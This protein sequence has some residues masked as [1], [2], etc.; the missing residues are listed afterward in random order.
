MHCVENRLRSC[1]LQRYLGGNLMFMESLRRATA[2]VAFSLAVFASILAGASPVAAQF[3]EVGFEAGVQFSQQFEPLVPYGGGAAWGDFDRDGVLDLLLTQAVGCN[4]LFLGEG[5]GTFSLV[6]DAQVAACSLTTRGVAVADYDNDGDSDIYLTAFGTNRLLE[7][8][9]VPTGSLAFVDV[10]DTSGISAD[11]GGNSGSAA[12]GDYD[13]DGHLDLFVTNHAPV[14][15]PLFCQPDLLWHNNGDGTFTDVADELGIAV[16]GDQGVPG[17]GLAATWSDYDRDGDVDL[18]VVNDFGQSFTPNRLFRNDGPHPTLP[19]AFTDV[20]RESGFD[21]QMFGMGIAKGDLDHDGDLD[22]Y[23]ADIGPNNLAVNAGDGT[24]VES[25]E[26]AGVLASD[27]ETWLGEGLVSWGVGFFDLDL[28]SWEDLIVTNGGAPDDAFPNMFGFSYVDLNPNYIYRNR[29]DGTFAE[30]HLQIGI[31]SEGF[32]RSFVAAD[33]D[34]DGDIDL[35]F[36]TLSGINRLYR[37]DQQSDRHWLKI[38][39]EGTIGNRD[40]YGARVLIV[41]DG[42]KQQREVDG[43]SSF[44]GRHDPTLHFGLGSSDTVDRIRVR[45]LSGETIEL[46]DVRQIKR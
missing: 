30:R 12:W 13:R 41:A 19:W 23:M 5:D 32:H 22:Y 34:G 37:N 17:C 9:I 33:Y 26:A 10:S 42:T 1:K 40:A 25:A 21:Y 35:H 14:I 46:R 2:G 29:G 24:F 38:R 4:R 44:L 6:A 8:R 28:D 18:M 16:G 39:L 27:V 11:G 43:G 45:F 3:T 7:N 36:G 15:P 31:D 20:S